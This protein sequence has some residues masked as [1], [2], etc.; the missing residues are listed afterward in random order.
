MMKKLSF[1]MLG[2]VSPALIVLSGC[3]GGGV[4]PS[5]NGGTVSLRGGI[6]YKTGI[7]QE[8]ATATAN[9]VTISVLVNG[10]VRNS[11]LP[12]NTSVEKGEVVDVIVQDTPMI[13]GLKPASVNS[14]E[15]QLPSLETGEPVATGLFLQPDGTFDLAT[16]RSSRD[17]VPKTLTSKRRRDTINWFVDRI[18]FAG[19]QQLSDGTHTLSIRNGITINTWDQYFTPA[20]SLTQYVTK[21][22]PTWTGTIPADG[23]DSAGAVVTFATPLRSYD[24]EP[25]FAN[26][27]TRLTIKV[28]QLY[29]YSQ[30]QVTDDSGLVTFQNLTHQAHD[31]IPRTGVSQLNLD[32]IKP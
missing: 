10:V 3:G 24:N 23:G 20:G 21:G 14:V 16:G 15:L 9:P 1:K 19:A 4:A 7:V 32:I 13:Q 28:N 8:A 22:Q 17:R 2:L 11:Y 12:K 18:V 31:D 5:S 27:N 6:V 25:I 29:S 30:E 26:W